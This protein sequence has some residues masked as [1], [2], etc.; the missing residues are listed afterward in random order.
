M[1]SIQIKNETENDEMDQD[2]TGFDRSDHDESE[3]ASGTENKDSSDKLPYYRL[4]RGSEGTEKK[5]KKL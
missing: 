2:I 4:Q 5:S 3:S 1:L